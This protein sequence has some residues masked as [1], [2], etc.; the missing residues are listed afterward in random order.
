MQRRP[1]KHGLAVDVCGTTIQKLKDQPKEATVTRDEQRQRRALDDQLVP[2][3]DVT[4][5][6]LALVKELDPVLEHF[7]DVSP[8]TSFE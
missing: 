3:G 6:E 5:F 7:V 1:T 2:K 4:S 8:P